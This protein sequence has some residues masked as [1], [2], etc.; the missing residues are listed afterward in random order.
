M[1]AGVHTFTKRFECSNVPAINVN[2][3]S[4][5]FLPSAVLLHAHLR[6]LVAHFLAPFSEKSD[7][8]RAF[9]RCERPG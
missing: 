1:P 4:Y 2:R 6:C 5:L 9:T 8:R 7:F 3:K